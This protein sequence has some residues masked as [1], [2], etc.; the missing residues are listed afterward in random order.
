MQ[1]W[2]TELDPL[3]KALWGITIFASLVFTVQ[4]ILTFVGMDS[5]L[6]TGSDFDGDTPPDVSHPF[7][8]FTFRNFINFFL[9]FGWTALA[10]RPVMES[11]G[12]MLLIAAVA[13][14]A[15]VAAVMYIFK[16]LSGMEQS[17]NI[18]TEQACGCTGNV[19]LTIP[20]RRQGEG[21]VQIAIGGAIREYN[22]V[23][24]GEKLANGTPVRVKSVI[25]DQTLL[26]EKQ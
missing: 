10:L 17:G 9:G 6:G 20:G 23:T 4:T 16:W 18:R 15:L 8:L 7:Q 2:W 19:Y 22:A 12:W 14:V 5:D 3:M 26:V 24:D 25:N 1:T 11:T 21:K 13:G